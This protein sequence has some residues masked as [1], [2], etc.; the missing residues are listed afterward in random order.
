MLATAQP[1]SFVRTMF[2]DKASD[3]ADINT[4]RNIVRE[5]EYLLPTSHYYLYEKREVEEEL[6]I[7]LPSHVSFNTTEKITTK[8]IDN[9]GRNVNSE[10]DTFRIISINQSAFNWVVVVVVNSE[11]LDSDVARAYL[12][13]RET[14]TALLPSTTLL[15]DDDNDDD[16]YPS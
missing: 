16:E 13:T 5:H 9:K 1:S 12:C 4:T 14:P 7:W 10:H 15:N 11:Q 8:L 3:A 2:C 6:N